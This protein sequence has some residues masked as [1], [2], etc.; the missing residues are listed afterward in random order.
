MNIKPVKTAVLGYAH[1]MRTNFVLHLKECS[2]IEI[3]GIY[4]RG[5]ERRLQAEQDG[6]FATSNLDE[7]LSIPGLE[8]VIIG[9][10]NTAHKEQ[11]IEAAKRGLHIMCEKPIAL[12]LSDAAEMTEAA[13][14]ANL[15]T[16]VNHWSP[17]SPTFIQFKTA[18]QQKLGKPWHIY[19]RHTREFGTWSQGARHV[20]VANPA[21][22]GGWTFHHLCHALNDACILAGTTKA[23]R[24][25]H[26]MQKSTPDCP[27][28]EIINSLITFDNGVTAL[29]TDGLCIGGCSDMGAQCEKG[30]IRLFGGKLQI[31]TPGPYDPTQRPGSLSKIV[32]S[33]NVAP[34]EKEIVRC[35]HLFA[36]AIRGGKNELLSFGFIRDQ[37]KILDAMRESSKTGKSI[38]L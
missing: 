38:D 5:E 11:A 20:N 22:S 33:V 27:S 28:E 4:N 21:D 17:F 15:V 10:A 25:Y 31:T 13:E 29:L 3:A 36:Q 19:V 12:S 23:V 34:G 37:Y 18:M 8:A 2:S 6:F 26:L 35:G 7:I 24:V 9:T 1:Y 16:Q 30:D 14:K 32:E